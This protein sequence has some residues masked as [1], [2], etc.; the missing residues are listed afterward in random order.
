M[1]TANHAFN[2]EPVEIVH[3]ALLHAF[4]NTFHD[5]YPPPF[6]SE[7]QGREACDSSVNLS[8]TVGCFTTISIISALATRSNSLTDMVRCVKDSRRQ[9]PRNCLSHCTPRSLSLADQHAFEI[10]DPVEIIFSYT[11]LSQQFNNP[12]SLFQRCNIAFTQSPVTVTNLARFALIDIA[13][14]VVQGQLKIEITYNK[15]MKGQDR[16]IQWIGKSECSLKAAAEELPLLKPCYTICDFPLLSL[17]DT[18][19]DELSRRVLP[20]LGL[21]SDQVQDIYPSAPV[22]QGMMMSQ[23]KSPRPY[24]T[25]VR[26]T[27]KSTGTQPVDLDRLKRAWKL[28]ASR[29]SILRTIFIDALEPSKIKNQLV[30]K[31]PPVD[32]SVLCTDQAV[33]PVPTSNF[34]WHTD[35]FNRRDTPQ[36]SLVLVQT[37]SGNLFCDL[38]INHTMFDGY[39]LSL[40]RQEICAAYTGTLSTTPAPP[41]KMYIDYLHKLP[42]DEGKQF[43]QS[44]LQEAQACHFPTLWQ[45][46][47]SHNP[48]DR[49]V[50]SI[51]LDSATHHALLAFCQR[52]GVTSSNV[53][54]LA[55]GLLLRAVTGSDKVC[56]G[57]ATSGRDA[58]FPGVDMVVGPLI[59]MLL[60]FLDFET[61]SSVLST[62]QKV[63]EDYLAAL[64]FQF[65]PLGKAMQ[66]SGT[67]GQGIVNTAVFAQVGPTDKDRNQHEISISD[68]TGR[69]SPDVCV[70][71]I[72][73]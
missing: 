46:V 17:S 11:D 22:Q 9:R 63:Q 64:R 47:T 44:Y 29:H 61:Q 40:I 31:D 10:K 14:S 71:P 16:I 72:L 65:I 26:W 50:F 45:T 27:V 57:Y 23:A 48:K 12:D 52:H 56:F 34:K 58:P 35:I 21:S 60:C 36:H 30:L 8:R 54:Y 37:A 53:F 28:V 5:R 69:G 55:W 41:Y 32:V 62:M 59:N 49:T 6:F 1:S 7:E 43:W 19:L 33:P 3:A 4:T 24:W 18:T 25:R 42:M 68:Q 2:T 70:P 39:S 66:L 20:H 38:E 67:F 15:E 73:P 51:S 13:A